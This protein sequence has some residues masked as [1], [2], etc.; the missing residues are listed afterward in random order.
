MKLEDCAYLIGNDE[1][2]A[3]LLYNVEALGKLK[4]VIFTFWGEPCRAGEMYD[5]NNRVSEI[6]GLGQSAGDFVYCDRCDFPVAFGL[7][8]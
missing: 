4:Y 1:F 2:Y 6:I 7:N 8:T 3:I 5:E